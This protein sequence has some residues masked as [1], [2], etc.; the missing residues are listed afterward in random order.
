MGKG[1]NYLSITLLISFLLTPHHYGWSQS[2]EG[3]LLEQTMLHPMDSFTAYTFNKNEW[4]FNFPFTPGWFMWGVTNFMTVELDAEAWLGGVPSIN[5]RFKMWD[6]KTILPAAAYETMYQHLPRTINLISEYEYLNIRRKGDSWF[7][8]INLS[9]KL[10]S[11]IHIHVS[12]GVTYSEKLEFD[13]GE[14]SD[15]QKVFHEDLFEPDLSIGLGWRA[16]DWVS[17][18]STY[19]EGVTFIYVDN[20]PRK[21]QYTLGARFA[22][23]INKSKR[24]LRNLRIELTYL[25]FS[26]SDVDETVTG[27]MGYLYWQWQA[28]S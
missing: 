16:K 19:S 3:S 12:Q 11:K 21:T 14:R 20:V 1:Q 10:L 25:S 23:F 5:A 6:Q 27:P 28:G 9:W 22:P 18:H 2:Q 7:N 26:F 24:Y 8:R 15:F 13:N 17:F 4:T